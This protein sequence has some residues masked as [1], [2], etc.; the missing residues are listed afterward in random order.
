MESQLSRNLLT[1]LTRLVHN[2]LTWSEFLQNLPRGFRVTVAD[3]SNAS[4]DADL[5][6]VIEED[7]PENRNRDSVSASRETYTVPSCESLGASGTGSTFIY[8]LSF[9]LKH[10][11]I[12]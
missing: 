5:V 11:L 7:V 4:S 3:S 6:P 9:F 12:N 1:G 2:A 8:F 10:K